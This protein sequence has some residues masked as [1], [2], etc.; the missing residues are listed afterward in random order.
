MTVKKAIIIDQRPSTPKR[1]SKE[2]MEMIFIRSSVGKVMRQA[3][4][5]K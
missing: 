2:E 4:L 5:E 1:E 3:K